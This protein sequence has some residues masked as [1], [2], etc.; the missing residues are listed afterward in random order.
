MTGCVFAQACSHLGIDFKQQS[1]SENLAHNEKL[2]EHINL[3][4]LSWTNGEIINLSTG[5]RTSESLPS[6]KHQ[7]HH[8]KILFECIVLVWGFPSHL[9]AWEIRECISKVYG[10]TSVISVYHLDETAVFVQFSRAEM[11]T[12][13]LDLKESLDRNNDPISVLHPLA[14]LLEGGNTCAGSYETYKEICSSTVSKVLFAN[15]AKAVGFKWKTKLVE[16]SK[17]EFKTKEHESVCKVK[18]VNSDSSCGERT[19]DKKT[20]NVSNDS[21][22]GQLSSDEIIDSFYTP[23]A[24][25]ISSNF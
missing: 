5:N 17:Q 2:Q 11:V 9:K 25:Q 22:Y 14:K 7:S 3:L 6:S 19:K 16:S 13:F 20:D 4:Y 10:P 8:P 23:E 24:K 18:A 1:S 12:K 15:Q 21:S